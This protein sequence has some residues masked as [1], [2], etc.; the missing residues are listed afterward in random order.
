MEVIESK[1]YKK[2]GANTAFIED[3]E[4]QL[5]TTLPKQYKSFLL[6]SN[7]GE[8]KLG[9]NYIYI[10]AIEDIIMIMEYKNI[11]KKSIWHLAWM[12]ILDIFFIC[13]TI[14]YIGWIWEI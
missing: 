11:F 10:W 4:K 8:G 12:V 9:D 14:V 13:L 3:V 7:G 1:W 5:N 6:W 2:D